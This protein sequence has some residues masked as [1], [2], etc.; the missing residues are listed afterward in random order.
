[1]MALQVLSGAPYGVLTVKW[2]LLGSDVTHDP[3]EDE[4]HELF[5]VSATEAFRALGTGSFAHPLSGEEIA[6]DRLHIHYEPNFPLV[7]KL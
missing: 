2:T 7:D 4:D 1:M 5:E 3:L 6:A